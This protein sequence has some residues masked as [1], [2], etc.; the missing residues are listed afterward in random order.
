LTELRVTLSVLTNTG[1]G[2][3]V[4]SLRRLTSNA[5]LANSAKTL[6]KNWKALVPGLFISNIFIKT[7]FYSSS[8][9]ETSSTSTTKDDKP[10][11]STSTS[12]VSN[13]ESQKSKEKKST[14]T[15]AEPTADTQDPSRYS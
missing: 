4:N 13:A 5:E 7:F 8:S 2:K 6:V 1:I 3:T 9:L 14:P 15:K 10:S 11:T 12:T